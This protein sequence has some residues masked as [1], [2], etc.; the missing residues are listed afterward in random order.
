LAEWKEIAGYEGLYL[1]S[2]E[3]EIVALPKTT[4]SGKRTLH[5][6]AKPIK[7]GLRGHDGLFYEFVAL[8]NGEKRKAY[9]VHRLVAE[10]FIPNP[11]NK[12]EVNHKNGDKNNNCQW[13]LEWVTPYENQ[14][15]KRYVLGADMSGEN[16]PMYGRSG[17][18]NAKFKDWVIAVNKDGT[19]AGR[20]ATQIEAAI[21]VTGRKEVA[22]QISRCLSRK[23]N[24]IFSHGYYWLYEKEYENMTKAD[25]KPCELLE[26]LTETDNSVRQSASK[27]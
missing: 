22:N 16:N 5:R 1:I 24:C 4:I 17:Q 23:R 25:L 12:T 3:G 10:A 26:N 7:K 8:Y 15:H 6:K 19:K 18:N 11:D 2:N 21:A 27:S 14:M 13:N 20:Y 9:S